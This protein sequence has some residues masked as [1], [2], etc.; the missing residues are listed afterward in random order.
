MITP[1]QVQP[2]VGEPLISPSTPACP[3]SHDNENGDLIVH[4]ESRIVDGE[5]GIYL[6]KR[7]LGSGHFGQVYEVSYTSPHQDRPR[8]LAMKISRG[9]I[10]AHD[11]FDYESQA[12]SFVSGSRVDNISHFHSCFIFEG[13]FCIVTELLG[14]SVLNI[15]DERGF[16]GVRLAEIQLVLRDLLGTLR[17]L[18]SFGLVHADI[19]PENIL[20]VD[21]T[22]EQAKVIDFGSCCCAGDPNFT[23]VQSRYYRAP[24]VALGI[25]ID[26]SADV[27][28]AGCVAAEMMLGLP[29]FPAQSQL[30]LLVL[31]DE[32]LGPLP[33]TMTNGVGYFN[34]DGR[35]KPVSVLEAEYG[36]D[37]S[38]F[39]PY[40]VHT[41]LDDIILSF[42]FEDGMTSDE[43]E[44]EIGHRRQFLA[45]LHQMLEL[46]PGRRISAE[47]ALGHPFM[48]ISFET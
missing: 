6:M 30:H 23:Y 44:R 16:A 41:R 25:P 48:H 43:I 1:A 39:Q 12:L 18:A 8:R 29:L 14:P 4:A 26:C 32:M 17:S 35:M 45:L 34:D 7:R 22:H 19:K 40:F 11:Q 47:D 5:G 20:Y 13:H 38:N 37:L 24:E 15:L 2:C 46:D 10:A 31:I 21:D 28:S 33:F 42:A 9:D 3:G 36:L 27:W